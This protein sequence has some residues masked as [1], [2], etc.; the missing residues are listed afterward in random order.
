MKL[1]KLLSA[2]ILI[3]LALLLGAARNITTEI[4]TSADQHNPVA[5]PSIPAFVQPPRES[6]TQSREAVIK[7]QR[8]ETGP[9]GDDLPA[10]LQ[11]ISTILL[12]G[13]AFWQMR[14]RS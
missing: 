8:S 11:A 9:S 7:N 3:V 2:L 12:V 14:F 4:K 6:S 10:W 1:S 5:S 13:F